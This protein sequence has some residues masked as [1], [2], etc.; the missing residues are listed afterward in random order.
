MFNVSS[1]EKLSYNLSSEYEQMF[2][3]L[4]ESLGNYSDY[5]YLFGSF[6]RGDFSKNSDVD[7]L[8]LVNDDCYNNFAESRKFKTSINHLIRKVLKSFG[9]SFDLMVYKYSYYLECI[10]DGTPF[11]SEIAKDLILLRDVVKTSKPTL[12]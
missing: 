1:K 9:V 10:K 3:K 5:V 2:K 11:E 8:L 4:Y 12:I 7:L 6:S